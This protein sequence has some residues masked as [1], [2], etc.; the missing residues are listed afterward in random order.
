MRYGLWGRLSTEAR[1]GIATIALVVIGF[2]GFLSFDRLHA[3][4]ASDRYVQV[5]TTVQKLVRVHE[6]GRVVVRRVP[7]VRTVRRPGV[8][9]RAVQTRV[10]PGGT[11]VV[12]RPVVREKRVVIRV[13]G[14]PV[15]VKRTVTDKQVLTQTQPVTVVDARTSIGTVTAVATVSQTKTVTRAETTTVSQTQTVTVT[16]PTTVTVTQPPST[17]T[18]TTGTGP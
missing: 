5:V 11:V 6:Q 12:T 13:H 1:F 18:V 16:Q 2:G 7:V 4:P 14:K 17:V 3:S 10:L 15:T 8:T 9:V